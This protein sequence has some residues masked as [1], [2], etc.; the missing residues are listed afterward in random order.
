MT[1]GQHVAP[2]RRGSAPKIERIFHLAC[3]C[4]PR[5][6]TNELIIAPSQ[7]ARMF[8]RADKHV[9]WLPRLPRRSSGQLV[10]LV[11]VINHPLQ[12][13]SRAAPH[14]SEGSL[15]AA[16][17]GRSSFLD[18]MDCTHVKIA[19]LEIWEGVSSK[20]GLRTSACA[21]RLRQAVHSLSRGAARSVK[22]CESQFLKNGSENTYF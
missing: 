19:R 13:T 14:H 4:C 18:G 12:M 2:L 21:Q 22:V 20:L 8:T 10:T 11:A 15:S 1:K 3:W 9:E 17:S 5:A 6:I 7:H 16:R